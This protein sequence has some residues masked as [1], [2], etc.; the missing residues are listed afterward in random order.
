MAPYDGNALPLLDQAVLERLRTELEDDDAVWKVFV[1][2]F[3][4]HLP[5]RTERLRLTLTTG[6]LV[7]ALDAVLS[8]KTSS[9]MVGAERLASL[10]WDLEQSLRTD[11]RNSEPDRVLPR[12]AAAHLRIITRCGRQTS[13]LLQK[14]LHSRPG[15]N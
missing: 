2:N 4:A 6:D 3:I 14:Y 5:Q 12:L 1:E 10:A 8:L 7:G 13:Y 9:Q 15:G 11:A